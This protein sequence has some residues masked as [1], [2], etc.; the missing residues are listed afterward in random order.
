MK[1]HHKKNRKWKKVPYKLAIGAEIYLG[2]TTRPNL[3]TSTT[4]IMLISIGYTN[5]EPQH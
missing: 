3:A 4:L 1:L 5:Y 2:M